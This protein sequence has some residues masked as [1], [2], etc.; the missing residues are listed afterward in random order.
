MSTG[1]HPNAA[2]TSSAPFDILPR[3][4]G[5]LR[6]LPLRFRW[7]V[8][9]RHPYYLGFWTSARRFHLREPGAGAAEELIR[10]A[11]IAILGAIGVGG[12]PSD[13]VLEFDQ[14]MAAPDNVDW[15]AG[16][17]HPISNR[18]LIGL[19]MAALPESS[20]ADLGQ[21]LTRHFSSPDAA[22]SH[23][24]PALVEWARHPDV[25]LDQFVDEPILSISP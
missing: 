19:L 7:E 6:S 15:L 3:P 12:M 10:Q 25:N 22:G 23:R 14:L 24:V 2:S 20:L 17:I 21:F 13:P 11:A 9:R 4:P 8:T 5:Q 1:D 18:G 16:T